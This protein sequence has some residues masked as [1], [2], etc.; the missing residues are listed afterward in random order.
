MQRRDLLC[1]VTLLAVL[2]LAAAVFLFDNSTAVGQQPPGGGERGGRLGAMMGGGGTMCA[3][4]SNL[5]VLRGSS[6]YKI[7]ADD[8]SIVKQI[9]LD[10]AAGTI[11]PPTTPP[12]GG[13]TK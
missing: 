3:I 1:C 7:N 10:E 12:E 2:A 8:L 9:S 5:Y 11:K 6:L 13:E 4:G